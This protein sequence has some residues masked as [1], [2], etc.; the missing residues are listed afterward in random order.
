M[1]QIIQVQVGEEVIDLDIDLSKIT[2]K[3]AISLE[4]SL[5]GETFDLLMKGEAPMRPSL[6]RAVIFA[7]LHTLYPEVPLDGFDIDLTVLYESL[8]EEDGPPKLQGVG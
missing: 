3:E 2:M 5:D 1:A 4:E 8:T 6:I 7:K